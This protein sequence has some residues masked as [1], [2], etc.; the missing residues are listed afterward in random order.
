MI[1]Y[2][3]RNM[4]QAFCKSFLQEKFTVVV[5]LFNLLTFDMSCDLLLIVE[6]ALWNVESREIHVVN[7]RKERRT[8]YKLNEG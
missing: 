3:L 5:T 8:S 1:W 2:Y 6:H 4:F 7:M